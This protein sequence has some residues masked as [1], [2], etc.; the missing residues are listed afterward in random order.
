MLSY[1]LIWFFMT[2]DLARLRSEITL[3]DEKLLDLLSERMK[4]SK[5]V[6][7]YKKAHD[8]PVFDPKREEEILRAYSERVDFEV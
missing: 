3:I 4:I 2:N 7:L 5:S 8:L 1:K 6:A